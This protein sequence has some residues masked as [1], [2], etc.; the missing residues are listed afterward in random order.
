MEFE[1]LLQRKEWT[2]LEERW[3]LMQ[4]EAALMREEV[5]SK[6]KELAILRERHTH[7]VKLALER[8]RIET[9]VQSTA[10]TADEQ[11]GECCCICTERM[12]DP[13]SIPCGH[14]FHEECLTRWRSSGTRRTCPICRRELPHPHPVHGR[15]AV[16]E[17][18]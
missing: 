2:L 11:G 8:E 12:T 18:R 5:E 1:E 3:E 13:V 4:K 10:E 7:K 14:V 17:S 15:R 9:D 6:K 16:Q